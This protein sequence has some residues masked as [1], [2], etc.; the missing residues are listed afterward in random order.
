MAEEFQAGICGET[1][2][3]INNSTRSVFPIMMN[4]SSSSCSG[5]YSNWQNEFLGLKDT[6]SNFDVSDCSLSFLDSP[7]PPQL[8]VNGTGNSTS[9]SMFFDLSSPNSSN[10]SHPLL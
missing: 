5:S 3:N 7:K 6:N 10:W 9:N 1:W 2:W 4:S 8:S